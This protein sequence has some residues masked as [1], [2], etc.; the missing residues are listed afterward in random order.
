M[1]VHLL[2]ELAEP[3]QDA[4]GRY[5]HRYRAIGYVGAGRHDYD[6]NLEDADVTDERFRRPLRESLNPDQHRTD[7]AMAGR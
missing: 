7:A 3:V 1:V 2:G 4:F 6:L 5:S